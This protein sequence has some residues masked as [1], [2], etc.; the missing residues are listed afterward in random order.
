MIKIWALDENCFD[1][2]LQPIWLWGAER[3]IDPTPY[4]HLDGGLGVF[5]SA[6]VTRERRIIFSR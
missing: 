4:M 3:G 2:Y 6:F 5:G 1:Y